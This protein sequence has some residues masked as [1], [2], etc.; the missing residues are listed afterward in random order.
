MGKKKTEKTLINRIIKLREIGHSVSEITKITGIPKTT[1]FN[2]ARNVKVLPE[3]MA[4]LV[5][6]KGGS[7][8]KKR[9]K[10]KRALEDAREMFKELS[11]KEKLLILSVL[12]WA[13]GSKGDFRISNTDPM[14]IGVFL[15]FL[16]DVFKIEEK[17]FTLSVRIYEDLD[18]E[19]CIKYWLNI[20][21]M[22]RSQLVSVDVLSGK[23]NGKLKHG[24]CRL[25]L[26][27]GGDLL[28]KIAGINKIIHEVACPCSTMDSAAQS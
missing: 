26:A 23:K 16:R 3:F 21:N 13:E 5:S 24:M 6:K 28:K 7:M 15:N 2:Y 1:V 11:S 4:L 9:E 25:R 20:T 12:Y 8:F 14:L 17:R 18:R 22:S 19:K 10:E 27:K